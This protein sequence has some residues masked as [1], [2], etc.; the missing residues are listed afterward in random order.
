MDARA[1]AAEWQRKT[2]AVDRALAN[3]QRE[4]SLREANLGVTSYR[5]CMART[6]LAVALLDRRGPRDI[7]RATEL[8]EREVATRRE[9]FGDDHSFT[10]IA[11]AVHVNALLAFAETTSDDE[12]RRTV[13]G[14]AETAAA[15]LV[16][17]RQRRLGRRHSSTLRSL[18]AHARALILLG[19]HEE[20]VWLLR[21]VQAGERATDAIVPGRT[22]YLL[23]LALSQTG[24]PGDLKDANDLAR[25]AVRKLL[26][27]SHPDSRN[28]RQ[29]TQ[30]LDKLA[31]GSA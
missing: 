8:A 7:A 26:T 16:S 6:N 23:A 2:G 14:Q 12:E 5:T 9:T 27:H 4:V 10:W 18:R 22:D 29:A 28:V 3:Y 30:L 13:A 20:A 19:R 25:S 21:R 24:H 17:R 15:E 31:A 1:N 11:T